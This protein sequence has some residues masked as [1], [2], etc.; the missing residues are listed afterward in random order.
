MRLG[1]GRWWETGLRM[2]DKAGAAKAFFGWRV[3]AAVFLLAMFG[4]G[5]G[6]YGPPVY[7]HA[8]REARGWPLS[9][10]STAVTTHYLIG[11]FIVFN[12]PSAYR[13]WG[14][15]AITKAGC[16]ALAVGVSGWALA[17]E[18]WHL[19][20]ATALSG[21]GW[22]TMG[23]A[24]VNAI[25]S[26]WFVRTRPLALSSAYNG[27][28][29]G[30]IV[31]SPLWVWAIA[32]LGFPA[33]AIVIGLVMAVV[34]WLLADFY[35][36]RTPEQLGLLPDGDASCAATARAGEPAAV[37]AL[38]GAALWRDRQF[39]TLAAGMAIGLFA[40]IGL[41]AHMFSLL[42]PALGTQAAGLA[43]GAATVAAIVGRTLSGWLMPPGSDRRLIASASYGV[44]ILGLLAFCAAGGDSVS[45]LLAGVVLFGLG[46]GN[47]TSL[48]PLIAQAEFSREDV[49]RAVPAIVAV[50]QATYAF[51]PAALGLV[52]DL[53]PPALG[54]SAGAAP[55]LFLIVAGIKA[56]AI[57][58]F[59]SGRRR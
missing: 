7:L 6:F 22:A 55:V 15:G 13:R 24:A 2:T 54:A 41:L 47:A 42:V 18:P 40:Q 46:I 44:Q 49:V 12:L 17:R 39:L 38:P 20:L 35:F 8:V 3:V 29:V 10:V 34:T 32:H 25:V 14:I 26:P 31:F 19:F 16:V 45:W 50:S 43:A 58:S 9:L 21:A 36:S 51:S 53:F 11:A 52:R 48:P 30:G 1:I 27:A 28:S 4:W 37:P 23:A 59:L 33:A 5:F 56:C 57:A